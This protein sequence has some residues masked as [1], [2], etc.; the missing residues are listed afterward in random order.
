MASELRYRPRPREVATFVYRDAQCADKE[1]ALAAALLNDTS[2]TRS[3]GP[4]SHYDRAD[5]HRHVLNDIYGH[6]LV[7]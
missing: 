7:A 4:W 2:G 5:L 1:Y 3:R 6:T